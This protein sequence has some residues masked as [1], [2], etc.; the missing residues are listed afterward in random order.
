MDDADVALIQGGLARPEDGNE[1]ESLGGLFYE[2][3]WVFVRDDFG[4]EDYSDL[5][6]ARFAIGAD[7][8]TRGPLG[9]CALGGEGGRRKRSGLGRTHA[10]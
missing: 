9:W 10:P 4:A 5:R 6:H 1:I 7:G 3:H 8:L 2:P